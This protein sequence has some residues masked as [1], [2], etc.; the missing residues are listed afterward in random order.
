MIIYIRIHRQMTTV[1][2]LMI[3]TEIVIIVG[4]IWFRTGRQPGLN[5]D[6]AIQAP[7]HMIAIPLMVLWLDMLKVVIIQEDK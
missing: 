6:I 3:T 5:A 2:R 1:I 4:E 7:P